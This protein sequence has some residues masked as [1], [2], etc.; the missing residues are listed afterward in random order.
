MRPTLNLNPVVMTPLHEEQAL[1]KALANREVKA[2]IQLY[3]DYG[4]DLLI[5]GYSLLGDPA[6]AEEKVEDLFERL[7]EEG[8]FENVDPP[9]YRYL[10]AEMRKA[11]GE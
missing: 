6:E 2:F 3:K 9:L 5:L 7:W 4:E 8:D 11:C 1:L 10:A